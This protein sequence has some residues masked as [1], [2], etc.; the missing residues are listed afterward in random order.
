MKALR[1]VLLGI[2][3]AV[4]AGLGWRLDQTSRPQPA[5]PTQTA[6]AQNPAPAPQNP[7]PAPEPVEPAPS[8]PPP[9]PSIDPTRARA[10]VL[11]RLADAVEYAPFFDR[12]RAEFPA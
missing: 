1:L 12:Y 5:P 9:A 2:A 6:S 11:S 4:F 3:L 7:V 10:E 8:A